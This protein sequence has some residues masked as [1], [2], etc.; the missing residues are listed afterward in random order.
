MCQ[1]VALLAGGF[2]IAFAVGRLRRAQPGLAIGGAMATAFFVRILAAYGLSS[3]SAAFTLRGGDE[4][5]FIG[6]AQSLAR[7]DFI[8]TATT[9]ALT[10]QFHT[11]WFSLNFRA[12]E[13]PPLMM[14]R[15][16]VIA[17]AVCGI[18]LLAGAV[19]ELA[20]PRAALIAAWV[21]AFEPA[22]VFFSGILHKEP[23]MFL[24]EGLVVYGG[25]RLWKRGDYRALVPMIAGCLLATAT[26]PYVGWFL[27]AGS[28]V[29][30]LHAGLRRNSAS[31]S[32]ALS[33]VC[34]A[35]MVAFVPTVWNASSKQNLKNLQFSQDANASDTNANLSLE[36]V[37][38]S[39]RDKIIVNLPKRVLDIATRPYPWQLQNVSQQLGALGTLFLF[40][41]VAVLL[42]TLWQRGGKLM[43]RA[44]PL[45]YPVL[46]LL[47][48]Y[49]LSA[50]NA[51]TAFRYRTHVV[52]LLVALVIVLRHDRAAE[53]HI[54]ER[55]PVGQLH[56]I[57]GRS[58]VPTLAK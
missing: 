55:E 57:L 30:A 35:L 39:T 34:L 7:W 21:L 40:G 5:T 27:A 17:F 16:E 52:A 56:P 4:L 1:L 11:Y 12:F 29:I 24:A 51:G 23:F 32:L 44:G 38:Y 28:A 13:H 8:S 36:R 19:H 50:G 43:T 49:A 33:A 20:G 31:G 25:A 9:K 46:F 54:E 48:A 14:L 3:T 37:D 22:N 47:V 26:R 45:I 41:T 2:L 42:I 53:R 6:N 10:H 15:I 18:A 58:S